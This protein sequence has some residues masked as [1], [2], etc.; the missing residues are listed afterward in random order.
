MRK[1]KNNEF[2]LIA[3][4]KKGVSSDFKIL[5]DKYKDVSFSLACSILKN[6]QEAED[7]LQESF[8]KAFK[9]LGRFN[10]K[11]SFSTWLYKI[12]INTCNSKYKNLKR[13]YQFID[14]GSSLR[15]E[16][17]VEDTPFSGLN[18]K[19]RKDVVNKVLDS[20]NTDESLLLRLYYLSELSVAEIKDI[21]G[22]KESKI[23]VSLFRARKS[24][25]QKLEKMY[26]YEI[27]IS[28]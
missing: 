22:Y 8:I 18:T 25:E 28:S 24:F 17:V 6:E 3:R 1:N 10:F 23:K 7:A 11:S 19:E 5:V 9:G 21:T 16:T 20:L 27:T 2:E 4:I 15:N 14:S 12:V 26:G 13:K